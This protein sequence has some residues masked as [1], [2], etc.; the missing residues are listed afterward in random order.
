[1]YRICY[2]TAMSALPDTYIRCP[3]ACTA[4]GRVRIYQAKHECLCYM[5]VICYT[6]NTLLLV[7]QLLYIVTGIRCDCGP[8][9]YH[10]YDIS[11]L[12][13]IIAMTFMRIM[14]VIVVL[15]IKKTYNVPKIIFIHIT[16]MK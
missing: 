16:M 7:Y 14:V 10:C 1:M 2:N 11:S 5:Y 13:F 3:R 8:I 15:L 4:Q 6:S 12:Y 9:F